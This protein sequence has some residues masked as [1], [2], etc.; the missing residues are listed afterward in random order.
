VV[1]QFEDLAGSL[2]TKDQHVIQCSARGWMENGT[3]NE[4]KVRFNLKILNDGKEK[5]YQINILQLHGCIK[6]GQ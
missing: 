2:N 5:Y 1:L 3:L 4:C 6:P